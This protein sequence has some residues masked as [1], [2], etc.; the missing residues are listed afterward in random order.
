MTARKTSDTVHTGTFSF[1]NRT[2]TKNVAAQVT[3]N[4][5]TGRIS[6][7]A[8]FLSKSSTK[9]THKMPEIDVSLMGANINIIP[10]Y[11]LLLC[12][13]IIYLLLLL[14]IIII[15]DVG[16]VVVVVCTFYALGSIKTP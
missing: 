4:R 11:A 7:A 10:A 5:Q 16:V 9:Q 6:A 14:L 2:K 12:I 15:I 3:P 1:S 13:I 8:A